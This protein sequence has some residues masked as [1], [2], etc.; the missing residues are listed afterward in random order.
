[1]KN[2]SAV[3]TAALFLSA[4]SSATFAGNILAYNPDG[5]IIWSN[6]TDGAVS[7]EWA[8]T[9]TGEWHRTWDHL[10]HVPI[11]HDIMTAGV[12]RLYRVVED[13]YAPIGN[14]MVQVLYDPSDKQA[15]LSDTNAYPNGFGTY[16]RGGPEYTYYMS[17]YNITNAEFV[18][19]LNDAEANP[20][21]SRGTNM[22]FLS[23]GCIVL[24]SGKPSH[25][26]PSIFDVG[27]SQILYDSVSPIGARYAVKQSI[28]LGG[29]SFHNH[30]AVGMSWHGA[31]KYCNWLT[32]ITGRGE[33]ERCYSEGPLA[34][35]WAPVTASQFHL[36]FFGTPERSDWLQLKGYRLPMANVGAVNAFNEFYKAAAWNGTTNTVYGFGRDTID[37]Q[38]A[39][40]KNSGDPFTPGSTPVG[41]YDGTRRDELGAAFQTRSNA[42]L[43]DIFDLSG[44][45]TE[46][47]SEVVYTSHLRLVT[48]ST[49]LGNA[50]NGSVLLSHTVPVTH[51]RHIGF[52][53]I[54]THP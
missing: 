18:H 51:E 48:G 21:S 27:D 31:V 22:T 53:I 20:E 37:Q 47:T 8:A 6:V 26:F 44:N 16:Q 5:T 25:S 1:M 45:V 11:T 10:R 32:T 42:N 40:Y 4:I 46:W 30:P 52:R 7:I 54:T 19:F 23:N 43:Y 50:A 9:P 33:S 34:T 2:V 39:N 38:D 24:G 49:Y 41:Y 36:A 13:S 29:G 3:F 35:D 12:P 17:R 28:P 15:A 14:D